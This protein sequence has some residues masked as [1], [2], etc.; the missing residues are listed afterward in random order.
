MPARFGVG[1][2]MVDPK[3]IIFISRL[4]AVLSSTTPT[5]EGLKKVKYD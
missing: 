5:K 1:P 3:K 2:T 4:D